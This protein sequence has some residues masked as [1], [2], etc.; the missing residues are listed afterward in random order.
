LVGFVCLKLTLDLEKI[1]SS[2][3]FCWPEI[4]PVFIIGSYSICND[5]IEPFPPAL[6]LARALV[7]LALVP[8]YRIEA[9]EEVETG[10]WE[11]SLD[12]EGVPPS[13]GDGLLS[14][15]EESSLSILI[16]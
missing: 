10:C 5:S 3:I 16:S 4:L 8:F 15:T 9:F 1:Y 12:I 13:E 6:I 2:T 11:E 7:I 14:F